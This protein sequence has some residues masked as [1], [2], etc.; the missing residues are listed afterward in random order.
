MEENKA[1]A[2][3]EKS[4]LNDSRKK[5][6]Q[7]QNML[8]VWVDATIDQNTDDIQHTLQQIRS[9]V[10]D[11]HFCDNSNECLQFLHEVYSEK[12]LIII[13]GSLAEDL[14]PRIHA[15]PQLHAIFIFGDNEA[16]HQQWSKH[17]RKVR[18]VDS[19]IQPICEDLRL[20]FKQYD[21]DSIPISFVGTADNGSTPDLDRLEPSFMYTIL[22][23]DIFL[24][25]QHDQ[26]AQQKRV[27]LCRQE[28]AG[29]LRTLQAI[30]EFH[31]DYRPDRAVWWYTRERFLYSMLNRSLRRLEVS[32]IIEMGFFIHDLHQQLDQLHQQQIERYCGDP[33]TLYRG[34]RLSTSD[35]EKMRK[36]Q[37]GL[38]SFN[39]F[40]STTKQK[41]TS[42]LFVSGASLDVDLVGILYV[43]KID[44]NI[45]STPFADITNVSVF[46]HEDE[47][48]FSMHT[49]FR[50]DTIRESGDEDG[51]FEVELH[52][53]T[54]NDNLLRCITEYCDRELGTANQWDR[55]GSL[56]IK[57]GE[58][59]R[60]EDLY[61]ALLNNAVTSPDQAHY[62][63]TLGHINKDRG[64]YRQA[65]SYHGKALKIRQETLRVDHPDLA[66]SYNRIATVYQKM[67]EYWIAL[68]YYLQAFDIYEKTFP[69]GYSD[70]IASINNI[71]LL[72]ENMGDY[73]KA[74]SYLEKALEIEHKTLPADH[75][76]LATPYNNI[77]LVY[78]NM[79][80]Y[81]KAL[82]NYEQAL[83]IRERTLPANHPDFATS[84]NNIGMVYQKMGEYST[85]VSKLEKALDIYQKTL[86][87]DH[88]D[89]ATSYNN[90]GAVQHGRVLKSVVPLR[91]GAWNPKGNSPTQSSWL[92]NFLQQHWCVVQEHGR[93]LESVVLPRKSTWYLS[94]KS[95]GQSSWLGRLLQ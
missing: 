72:Y 85:A 86:P 69:A 15:L 78:E 7:V 2:I 13:S 56:L 45:H 81:S 79:G 82:S 34:Q 18:I 35:F 12:V 95:P 26:H 49:V 31:R 76:D 20:F 65:L 75:P 71:G 6:E 53:T 25:M 1:R 73:S 47:V 90:I 44:P 28:Y 32:I 41:E 19:S 4:M 94:E 91:T 40:L 70:F 39:N 66:R 64:N 5:L 23:K 89:L 33:F 8:L 51:L 21:Q 24:Q 60:A 74:L 29:N 46:S 37:G 16:E 3:A 80:E 22:F 54:D 42:L 63:Q 17:W 59:R 48:L 77:G 14:V 30:E 36:T 50:I 84:Y 52:L 68:F 43:L 88:P 83:G 11:V 92:R 38:L 57:M 87:A 55:L 27:E 10:N 61:I 9:V 67:G 62:N 58:Q 93:V